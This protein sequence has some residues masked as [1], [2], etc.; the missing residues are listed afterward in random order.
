MAINKQTGLSD[1]QES[2]C[3]EYV[4]DKNGTRSAIQAGYSKKTADV[5]A[6][7]LLRLVKIRARIDALQAKINEKN[8]ISADYVVKKFKDLA[9][10]AL[11]KGDMVNENR[12]LENLGKHTGIFE[13]DNEQKRPQ[14]NITLS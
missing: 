3:R 14:T 8:E 9:E 12:A 5:K 4:V 10:R 6:S 7:Q 13:R 2:F 11:L 1:I